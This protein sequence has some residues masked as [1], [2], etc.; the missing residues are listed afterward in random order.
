MILTFPYYDPSGKHNQVF[1]CQLETLKS[2]FDT[3]CVSAVPPTLEENGAFAQ[4]LEKQ[5]CVLFN[6]EPESPIGDHSREGLRLA[7]EQGSQP[8]FFG[9]LGR[10]LFALDTEWRTHFLRDLKRHQA[11]EFTLFERSEVAWDTHPS[12]YREIEQM[13]SRMFELLSGRDPSS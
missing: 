13:I 10:I 1:Q 2:A 4:H 9:F 8:V 5:G 6:N 3:I 12:N 11:T 7:V